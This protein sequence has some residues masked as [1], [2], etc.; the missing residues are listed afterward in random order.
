MTHSDDDGLV[1]PPRLAPAQIV[2]IPISFKA[3]DPEALH[4][5]CHDLAN[6][7]RGMTYHGRPIRVEVDERDL[8]GGDKIWSWIKK[9]VPIRLEVGPRDLASG[10]VFM[11]R[12]DKGHKDKAGVPR[13]EFVS[14]VTSDP[15]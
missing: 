5:W 8:R 11:G 4:A 14:G 12:R 15:R 1:L 2:I 10:S 13:D 6:E 9:G 7:L 3:D